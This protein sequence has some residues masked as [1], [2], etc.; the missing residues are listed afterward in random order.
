MRKVV[1]SRKRAHRSFPVSQTSMSRR[2]LGCSMSFIMT[3]SRSIPR[4]ICSIVESQSCSLGKTLLG[5]A[6][7]QKRTLSAFEVG[8]AA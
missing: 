1:E 6:A 2:T 5:A 7:R 8:L 4:S 3:I